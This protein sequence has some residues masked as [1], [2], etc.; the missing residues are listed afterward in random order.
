M[1]GPPKGLGLGGLWGFGVW[2]DLLSPC[3]LRPA[4][5]FGAVI[6][7]IHPNIL[8][9]SWSAAG[10]RPYGK[11]VEKR[12]LS[13]FN[14]DMSRVLEIPRRPVILNPPSNLASVVRIL[15]EFCCSKFTP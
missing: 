7:H 14:I 1:G 10:S 4:F 6:P 5:L 8:C 2:L 12:A 3:L 11:I 13:C 9:S 15:S